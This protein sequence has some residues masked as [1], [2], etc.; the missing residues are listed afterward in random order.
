MTAKK[1]ASENIAKILNYFPAEDKEKLNY[2]LIGVKIGA[3]M[4]VQGEGSPQAS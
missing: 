3:D 1:E 4:Q 2:L